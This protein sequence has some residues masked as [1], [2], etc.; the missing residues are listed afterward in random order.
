VAFAWD[1]LEDGE[2]GGGCAGA[3]GFGAVVGAK[4]VSRCNSVENEGVKGDYVK[5]SLGVRTYPL[6]LIRLLS[7]N[8][9][10]RGTLV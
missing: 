1:E 7:L 2:W 8:I 9:R 10:L 6:P 5:N 3:S 4:G